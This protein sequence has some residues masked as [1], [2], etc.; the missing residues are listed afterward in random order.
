MAAKPRVLRCVFMMRQILKTLT[1]Q[2]LTNVPREIA[3]SETWPE[4]EREARNKYMSA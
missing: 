1:F 4:W 2:I 3:I